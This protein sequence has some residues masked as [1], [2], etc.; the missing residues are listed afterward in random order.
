MSKKVSVEFGIVIL[1]GLILTILLVKSILFRHPATFVNP[2]KVED[3][4]LTGREPL[5]LVLS[6]KEE[7][8]LGWGM[9]PF[10]NP[11]SPIREEKAGSTEARNLSLSGVSW[12]QDRGAAIINNQIVHEGDRIGD[13]TVQYILK[14][15]VLLQKGDQTIE[16]RSQGD[17]K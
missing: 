8:K 15:H 2:S 12:Y 9:D 17:R 4:G 13:F 7:V 5:P 11:E 1:L 10:R 3:T 14:D 6:E 16:L